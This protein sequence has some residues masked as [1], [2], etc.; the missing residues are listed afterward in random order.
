ME[1]KLIANKNIYRFNNNNMKRR[2]YN[3]NY[4]VECK[5]LNYGLEN[6]YVTI[7]IILYPICIYIT[8]ITPKKKEIIRII[9]IITKK[10]L[11]QQ[12]T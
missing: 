4:V 1:V 2:K 8:Y 7:S 11:N 6:F 10:K 12:I 9:R 5:Y 3:T